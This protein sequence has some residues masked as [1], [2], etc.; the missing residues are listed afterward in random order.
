M[1]TDHI[2]TEL[3]HGVLTLRFNRL[4]KKNAVTQAMYTALAD[5]LENARNDSAVR[6]VLFAGDP[7]C[8]CSGNDILDFL[9]MPPAGTDSPVARFMKAV[10]TFTKPAVAAPAGIAVGIGVTLLLHCDLIYLGEQTKLNMP[11]VS[12][13]ICPELGSTYILPRLMGHPRASELLLLGEGFSAQKALEYG[14]V[15]SLHPNAEVEAYARE[16]A[17][18]LAALPPNA[19]RT[20]KA[21]LKR[22]TG[23]TQ[24]E[25]V[26]VEVDHFIPMLKQ[27][28]ALEAFGAFVQKRKPDFSKFS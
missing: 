1:S 25:A 19:I 13:G 3:Q 23:A 4:D 9:N 10:S 26:Q 5:A 22:W 2:V 17:L 11:F 28:E 20:T 18:K 16:K 12:L 14:L 24:A 27:P 7:T 15:N 21:L 8:F 6:V